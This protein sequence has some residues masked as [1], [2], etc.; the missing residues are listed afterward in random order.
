MCLRRVSARSRG[1]ERVSVTASPGLLFFK[2]ICL[3]P[4][5][6]H[7]FRHSGEE[8]SYFFPFG[9]RRSVR[10]CLL[11]FLVFSSRDSFGLPLLRPPHRDLADIAGGFSSGTRCLGDILN[12]E[13]AGKQ[14]QHRIP[15][16]GSGFFGPTT[17]SSGSLCLRVPACEDSIGP[18]V[19]YQILL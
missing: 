17:L 6:S 19:L 16:Y 7:A 11:N 9:S 10:L 5:F 15:I 12:G 14:I 3:V 13:T 18:L 4:V 2:G 1:Q 8:L